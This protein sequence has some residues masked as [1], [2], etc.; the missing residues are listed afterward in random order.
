MWGRCA[1]LLLKRKA[2][3]RKV[4][5]LTF[6]D[7]PGKRLTPA[8]LNIL[9]QY[10]AKATFFLLGKNIVGREGIVRLIAERGHEICSHGYDHL[11]YWMVSPVRAI[12]DIKLGWQA[13]DDAL[14]TK[15]QKYSFR[16]PNGKLNLFCLLYLLFRQ[17][18][19]VYWS[20]DS[21]DTWSLDK[22]DST[23][24]AKS[25]QKARGAV[26][27]AHDFDRADERINDMVLDSLRSALTITQKTDMQIL[28][29]SELLGRPEKEN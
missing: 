1:R 13:I 2:I 9:E 23:R 16:P 12:K 14:G 28:T 15:R 26:S 7:G 24:V 22:Q 4:L 17:V 25:A 21:G 3:K 10:N 29:V 18:P 20:L 8:I 27:L 5:V 6:D 11:H 19:I